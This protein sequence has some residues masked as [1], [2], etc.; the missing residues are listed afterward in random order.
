[1]SNPV[2][3]FVFG[4]QT[5]SN[6]KAMGHEEQRLKAARGVLKEYTAMYKDLLEGHDAA[7]AYGVRRD[8]A[9]EYVE[10]ERANQQE[11]FAESAHK[12]QLSTKRR[13]K[14]S[15]EGDT[16]TMAARHAQE[17]E[18]RFKEPK[19]QAGM[20]RFEAMLKERL[21]GAATADAAIA[22]TKAPATPESS[23]NENAEVLQLFALLQGAMAAIE[24]GER[25]GRDT[26]ALR[27]RV[28]L[29]KKLLN[30]S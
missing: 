23:G 22:E 16:R 6:A 10:N 9:D 28:E 19:F 11:K 8:V 20:A 13:E 4:V 21:V 25:V 5:R 1:M 7:T 26:Q 12:R 27:E 24:E 30:L 14:E 3:A 29:Y 2:S 18:E 17:A 15:I